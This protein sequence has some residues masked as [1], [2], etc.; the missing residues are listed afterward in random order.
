MNIYNVELTNHCNATCSYC[1]HYKMTRE[2]G[3]MTEETFARVLWVMDNKYV[4][5][6][7]FGEPT[8]HP[9]LPTFITQARE[10][11]IKTEFSTNG[12]VLDREGV[13]ALMESRPYRIRIAYDEFQPDE[14][15]K[16]VLLYN[17]STI[18]HIHSVNGSL[19]E[20]KPFN[21][22]AGSVEGVS[23]YDKRL[24]CYFH[25]Y[26]Y[27]TVL[28][29]GR[30]TSCCQDYEGVTAQGTVFSITETTHRLQPLCSTCDRVQFADFVL[31]EL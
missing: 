10:K 11:G 12:G 27:F 13:K 4:T 26:N 19:E 20:K 14:F 7:N 23:E 8:L 30:I 16:Q 17:Q 28:W 1:P 9:L 25:K 22:F 18:V 5:L 15:I 24:P 3:F 21:T 29:D 31:E 6:H 2:M